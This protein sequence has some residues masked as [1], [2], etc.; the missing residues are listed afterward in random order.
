MDNHQWCVFCSLQVEMTLSSR[1]VR[2]P[3]SVFMLTGCIEPK[4]NR[5]SSLTSFG[6]S[7]GFLFP[8]LAFVFVLGSSLS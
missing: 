6:G 2:R 8:R 4:R 3:M 1:A 7:R 5:I